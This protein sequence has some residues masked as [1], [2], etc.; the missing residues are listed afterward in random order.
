MISVFLAC[1]YVCVYCFL[2]GTFSC[3]A[4]L[5]LPAPAPVPPF[6]VHTWLVTLRGALLCRGQWMWGCASGWLWGPCCLSRTGG[7]CEGWLS[8][9]CLG[10]SIWLVS[11][12]F[13]NPEAQAAGYAS[14]TLRALCLRCNFRLEQYIAFV[15][16]ASTSVMPAWLALPLS[17]NN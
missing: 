14:C 12:Y 15:S 4:S 11:L 2:H 13:I 10:A 17:N 8:P 5:V 16:K 3:S 9:D 6:C 1:L 7:C